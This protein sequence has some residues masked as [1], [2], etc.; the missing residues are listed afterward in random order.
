[1]TGWSPQK[2]RDWRYFGYM[3]AYFAVFSLV[4]IYVFHYT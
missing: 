3:M 2:V 1:M 4:M